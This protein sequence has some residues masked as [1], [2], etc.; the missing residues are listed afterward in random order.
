MKQKEILQEL[1]DETMDKVFA[2]SGN[3]LMTVPRKGMEA[4]WGKYNERAE[5]LKQMVDGMES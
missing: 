1:C 5:M 3:Y 2:C 4:E